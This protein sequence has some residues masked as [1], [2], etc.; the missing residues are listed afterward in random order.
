MNITHEEILT[1]IEKS[2]VSIEITAIKFDQS[3][4]EAG[5]D[6]LEMFNVFLAIEEHL[7]IKIPDSDIDSLDTINSIVQYLEKF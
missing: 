1:I 6:S 3:L 5:I 4:T 7:N 2:G